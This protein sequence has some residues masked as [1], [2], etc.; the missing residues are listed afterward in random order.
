MAKLLGFADIIAGLLF[1]ASFYQLDLPRGM[2]ILFGVY[3][4]FKGLIFITNFFSWIEMGAGILLAFG[5]TPIVPAPI[6]IGLAIFLGLRGLIS[7]FS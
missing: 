4:I 2:L 7:L 1:L 6:L 5:L 3:L